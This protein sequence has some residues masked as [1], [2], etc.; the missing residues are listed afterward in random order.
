MANRIFFK[1]GAGSDSYDL[2]PFVDINNFQINQEDVVQEWTDGNW[3]IHRGF[4]RTRISGTVDVGFK[5]QSDYNTFL[6]NMESLKT[7]TGQYYGSYPVTSFVNNAD[8]G[9]VEKS[10]TAYV[11]RVG[12]ATWDLVNGRQW[13]VQRL[14][15]TEV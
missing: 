8:S 10:Y 1:I 15:V 14:K 9:T 13:I 5:T 6:T 4:I 11:E 7:T 2:T 12:E 3:S